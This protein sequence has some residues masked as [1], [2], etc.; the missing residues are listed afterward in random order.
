MWLFLHF[1]SPST[2]APRLSD[3]STLT[4]INKMWLPTPFANSSSNVSCSYDTDKESKPASPPTSLPS[5]SRVTASRPKLSLPS[6]H[7]HGPT[8]SEEKLLQQR[9]RSIVQMLFLTIFILNLS[10]LLMI[11][12]YYLFLFFDMDGKRSTDITNVN[13]DTIIEQERQLSYANPIIKQVQQPSLNADIED[14]D[15]IKTHPSIKHE[16]RPLTSKVIDTDVNPRMDHGKRGITY[17]SSGRHDRSGAVVHDMLWVHAYAFSQN[18]TYGGACGLHN[19][20]PII[21]R[22][23]N[24]TQELID[25]LHWNRALNYACP[26][27]RENSTTEVTVER[28]FYLNLDASVFTPQWKNFFQQQIGLA[29]NVD[30][31]SALSSILPTE[32]SD[33]LV[34][35]VTT[36]ANSHE[37]DN[38]ESVYTI[39]V[40]I[41]RGDVSPCTYSNRYMSNDYYL[42]LIKRYYKQVPLQY[43]KIVVNIYSE[44]E[45]YES[46]EVFEQYGY[47]LHLDDSLYNVWHALSTA[48]VAILSISSFSYVPA[49]INPNTVVYTRYR[50]LP[51]PSWEIV[52]QHESDK[53]KRSV[54][55][56]RDTECEIK[57]IK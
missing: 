16:Q 20:E 3:P 1:Q 51:L 12:Q 43:E 35:A 6:Y 9:R 31:S 47:N 41:R 21:M 19:G 13:Q 27:N 30:L 23:Q 15:A 5:S 18:G 56:I 36:T 38:D 55:H 44:S 24:V 42:Q 10:F 39:A 4:M 33:N 2:R 28:D 48:N 37:M 49:I 54:R 45:S 52:E 57:A 17:F 8:A 11:Q 14:I 29:T 25:Q 40:H 32:K 22:Y 46:F 26:S 7:P 53:E 34:D 50:H